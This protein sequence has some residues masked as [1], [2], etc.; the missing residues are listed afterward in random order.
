MSLLSPFEKEHALP[1]EQTWFHFTKGCFVL[2]WVEINLIKSV[3]GEQI[4]YQ[5]YTLSPNFHYFAFISIWKGGCSFSWIPFIQEC[6]QLSFAQIGP[7]FWKYFP[8]FA[9]IS[10]QKKECGPHRRMHL[11]KFDNYWP[12]GYRI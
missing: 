9:L 4:Y 3:S 6:F 8:S 7:G 10:T 2:C 1:F 12:S 5:V 11:A